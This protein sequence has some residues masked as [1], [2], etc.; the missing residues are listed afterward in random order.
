MDWLIPILFGIGLSAATGIRVF[1]PFFIISLAFQF[2]LIQPSDDFLWL[3][4][5]YMLITLGVATFVEILGFYTPII[6]HF[7]DLLGMPL[8]LSAGFL[9]MF[10]VLPNL[11]FVT[12]K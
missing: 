2:N 5:K 7:M 3:N 9:S 10:S 1:L 6:D 11:P 12:R 4:N 8:V